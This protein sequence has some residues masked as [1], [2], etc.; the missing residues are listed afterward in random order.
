MNNVLYENAR[1]IDR[2]IS[3]RKKEF[4]QYEMLSEKF[5]NDVVLTEPSKRT[6]QLTHLDKQLEIQLERTERKLKKG[7]LS[8]LYN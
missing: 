3:K 2:N 5:K 8:R 1:K 7:P 6:K 4:G